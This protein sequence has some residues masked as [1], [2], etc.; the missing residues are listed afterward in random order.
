VEAGPSAVGTR[1]RIGDVVVILVFA[2]M[3]LAGV[4]TIVYRQTRGTSPP[5]KADTVVMAQLAF[6]PKILT[7]KKGAEVAW[8]NKDIAPHNVVSD[9]PE[10]QSSL[11]TP[12]KT[13][14][15]VVQDSFDYRC[16]IHPGMEAKVVLSG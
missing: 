4:V 5:A 14:K 10:I 7:V 13:F 1:P 11:I 3:V 16:T 9:S 8:E 15:V 2:G 6:S 12:G